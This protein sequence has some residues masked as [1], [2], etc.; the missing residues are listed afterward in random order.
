MT[1]FFVLTD[2]YIVGPLTG[3]ELREAALAGILRHDGIVGGSREGPWY[4]AAD[5]GLFSEK[6]AALPHPPDIHVPQYQV[7]GMP[8]AFQGPFKLRELIGFAARGMLPADALLQG[9]DSDEW[10][11]VRRYRVLA[12]VLAGELVVVDESGN[13]VVRNAMAGEEL[14]ASGAR[15]RRS[16]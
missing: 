6:K 7:R 16:S 13:V 3:V 1:E 2:R 10:I 9:D 14:E 12:A 4:S 11:E 8:G 5:I 15:R